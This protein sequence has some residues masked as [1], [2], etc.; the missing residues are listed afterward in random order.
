VTSPEPAQLEFTAPAASPRT[1]PRPP[2]PAIPDR[3]QLRETRPMKGVLQ[4]RRREMSLVGCA[5]GRSPEESGGG[6]AGIHLP[7]HPG[8]A[9][10]SR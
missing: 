4:L 1:R 10:T 8:Q 9:G 2:R 7:P 5:D 3:T 6:A